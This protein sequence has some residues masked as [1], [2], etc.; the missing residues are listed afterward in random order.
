MTLIFEIRWMNYTEAAA[1]SG[2]H[3]SRKKLDLI[4]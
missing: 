3:S 1:I 4:N 2:K